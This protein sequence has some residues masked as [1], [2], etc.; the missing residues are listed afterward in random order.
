MEFRMSEG[1]TFLSTLT[2]YL[3]E[4]YILP[5]GIRRASQFPLGFNEAVNIACYLNMPDK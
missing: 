5:S 1:F 4:N 2:P 3:L